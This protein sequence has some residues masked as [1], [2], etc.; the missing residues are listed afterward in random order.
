MKKCLILLLALLLALSLVACGGKK[1]EEPS[2]K[3]SEKASEKTSLNVSEKVSE[4]A[5][6][7]PS[8]PVE[9][10]N[11][12]VVN[13]GNTVSWW[14]DNVLRV[15]TYEGDKVTSFTEYINYGSN[16]LAENMKQVYPTE[17]VKSA[18]VKGS[19]LI[20]EHLES[21]FPYKTVAELH[22]ATPVS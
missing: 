16:V 10:Y 4:K 2:E 18:T 6:E 14:E 11:P 22:D 15:F 3:A 19:Y 21:N 17:S 12:P 9:E 7:K 20:L 1:A 8:E 5:S 13:D